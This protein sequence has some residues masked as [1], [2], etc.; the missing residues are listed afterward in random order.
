[1]DHSIEQQISVRDGQPGIPCGTRRIVTGD[2][3]VQFDI[4]SLL[5]HAHAAAT[6]FSRIR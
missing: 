5:D 6:N 1:V 3:A 4:L 2:E